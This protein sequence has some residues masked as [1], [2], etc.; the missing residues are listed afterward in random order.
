MKG[1]VEHESFLTLTLNTVVTKTIS[2]HEILHFYYL[3]LNGIISI[4]N[5]FNGDLE[6]KSGN[7]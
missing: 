1:K 3:L 2:I 5:I 7:S 4:M 6:Q